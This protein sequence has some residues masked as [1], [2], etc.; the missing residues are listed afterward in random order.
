MRTLALSLLLLAGPALAGQRSLSGSGNT[1]RLYDSPCVHAGT[2]GQIKPEWRDKFQ[3]ADLFVGK[4]R[5]YACWFL[6]EDGD[7][8]V[9]VEDGSDSY[10]PWRLFKE[11]FGV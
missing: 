11:D 9:L 3:K 8:Y 7:V 1:L 2:L 10:F 6:D 5:M 4:Q